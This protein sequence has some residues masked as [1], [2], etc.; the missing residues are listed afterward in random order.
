MSVS[1]CNV[2]SDYE[3]GRALTPC[4][5]NVACSVRRRDVRVSESFE[6]VT[7]TASRDLNAPDVINGNVNPC[8][9]RALCSFIILEILTGEQE[10]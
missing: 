6:A 4:G 10:V 1:P 5:K 8:T 7:E 9:Q 3:S 2:T